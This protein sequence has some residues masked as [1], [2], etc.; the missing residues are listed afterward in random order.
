M[1]NTIGQNKDLDEI[2]K[3]DSHIPLDM[4]K[5]R[6]ESKMVYVLKDR[7]E[8]VGIMRY[9]L[10]WAMIPFLE[11]IF[12]DEKY[13]LQGYGLR[14]MRFWEKEMKSQGYQYVMLSTQEDE[15]AQYFY[16]KIGYKEIGNF[17]PPNQNVYEIMFSKDI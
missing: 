14:M 17:L 15:E 5:S 12:V 16:R 3:Y 10:F 2:M 9:S 13:R 11:L 8:I 6:V 7:N 4:L 1:K